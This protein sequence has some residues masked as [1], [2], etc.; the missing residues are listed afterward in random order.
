MFF[1][2][3]VFTYHLMLI[4]NNSYFYE[5]NNHYRQQLKKGILPVYDNY[6]TAIYLLFRG[7]YFFVIL[8]GAL[9]TIGIAPTTFTFLFGFE[10][11]KSYTY[12]KWW[13]LINNIGV[14]TYILI[15]IKTCF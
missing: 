4:T 14:C 1:L 12:S 9:F 6:W 7:I 11:L 15:K 5:F 10:F 3:I 13:H 2:I 8:I